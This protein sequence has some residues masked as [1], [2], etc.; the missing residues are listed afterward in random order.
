MLF[1]STTEDLAALPK[2]TAASLNAGSKLAVPID[3]GIL[4]LVGDKALILQ[5]IQELKLPPAIELDAFGN[6]PTGR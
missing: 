1:R 3:Q 2:L 4:V 5:Q 6:A